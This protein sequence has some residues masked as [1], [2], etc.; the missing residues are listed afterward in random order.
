MITIGLLGVCC[1]L[2]RPVELL[3]EPF[4]QQPLEVADENNVVFAVEVNPAL[5]AV[6]RVVALCLTSLAS[7]VNLVKRLLVDIPQ[8]YIEV[9]AEWDVTIAMDDE[10]AYDALAV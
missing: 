3:D 2:I 5:I 1:P 7:V 9:L 8:H 6:L 10:T 4:G